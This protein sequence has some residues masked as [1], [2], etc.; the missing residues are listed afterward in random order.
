MD[1]NAAHS[2]E[3]FREACIGMR[4]HETAIVVTALLYVIALAGGY[5]VHQPPAFF[6]ALIV[7]ITA[8]VLQLAA[9]AWMR[10]WAATAQKQVN[11]WQQAASWAPSMP[12]RPRHTLS[13]A[14]HAVTFVLLALHVVG[15]CLTLDAFHG[16]PA[17]AVL[18]TFVV[19]IVGSIAVHQWFAPRTSPPDA[20]PPEANR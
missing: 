18:A 17:I 4:R 14:A 7:G 13:S 15:A 1:P 12:D 11:A 3:L 10:A 19:A 5:F 20:S 2:V 16:A 6:G 8:F 9:R